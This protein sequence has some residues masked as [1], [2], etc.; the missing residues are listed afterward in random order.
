MQQPHTG[1]AQLSPTPATASARALHEQHCCATAS[2][3]GIH[4]IFLRSSVLHLRPMES[5]EGSEFCARTLLDVT[6]RRGRSAYLLPDPFQWTELY[7]AGRKRK[8]GFP[9]PAPPRYHLPA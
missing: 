3:D 9:M 4:W 2:F 1:A 8:S 5:K 7:D 6:S